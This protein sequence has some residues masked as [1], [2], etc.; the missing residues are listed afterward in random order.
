MTTYFFD[1]DG[2]LTVE[3]IRTTD[4]S[5]LNALS[6]NWTYTNAKS[7]AV[8]YHFKDVTGDGIAD[9]VYGNQGSG[10]I[11][12]LEGNADGT[13]NNDPS[14]II[15]TDMSQYSN[16]GQLWSGGFTG[17]NS[18]FIE[19]VTGDGIRD[20]VVGNSQPNAGQA[21]LLV[22]AGNG[23]GTFNN[24]AI[25]T[26]G[27]TGTWASENTIIHNYVGDVGSGG[28]AWMHIDVPSFTISVNY[29]NSD[30]TM[31]TTA[32]TTN[33]SV[34][35]D[36][37]NGRSYHQNTG[38]AHLF[39]DVNGDGYVDYVY[40]YSNNGSILV[41]AGQADG[42]FDTSNVI[43]TDMSGWV[44]PNSSTTWVRYDGAYLG[45]ATG[46]G[47]LDYVAAIGTYTVIF[48]GIGDGTFSTTSTITSLTSGAEW[49][50]GTYGWSEY[51]ELAH[52]GASTT[53][54]A[55]ADTPAPNPSIEATLAEGRSDQ[56]GVSGLADA[57][58]PNSTSSSDSYVRDDGTDS[59]HNFARFGH[60]E[61]DTFSLSGSGIHLDLA[62]LNSSSVAN[63]EVIDITGRGSNSLTLTV[64]DV[65]DLLDHSGQNELRILA[66]ANDKVEVKGFAE[67]GQ[68]ATVDH[69]TYDIYESSDGTH[70]WVQE[71]THMVV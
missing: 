12:V 2:H 35:N 23:D 13:F 27:M 29:F 40:G 36:P 56:G 68:T 18:S 7:S 34:L 4:I 55:N 61:S 8:N 11:I 37:A 54:V 41:L 49:D 50:Q 66:D 14:Q 65:K 3:G 20:W 47:I 58:A 43:E 57:S 31:Q 64:D 26:F 44:G 48:E 21:S 28:K 45:D 22:F 24:N 19:D 16:S 67:T 1:P 10:A 5:F 32:V 51:G 38:T 63:A 33:V 42:T 52:I 62:K 60:S 9:F 30:G 6:P 71:D 46:D 70:L 39:G 69:V 25:E 15:Q 17:S 59:S 53:T